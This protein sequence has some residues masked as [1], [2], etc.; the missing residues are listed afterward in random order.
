MRNER[1]GTPMS[2]LKREKSSTRSNMKKLVKKVA[3]FIKRRSLFRVRVV[4]ASAKCGSVHM[5]MHTDSPRAAEFKLI[6]K[7]DVV[8]L[9]IF[10]KVMDEIL[11]CPYCVVQS[12]YTF[13]I[14]CI[15]FSFFFA[16]LSR[17]QD[18]YIF[19]A[20]YKTNLYRRNFA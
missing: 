3:S 9:D 2:P 11:I 17:I 14:L 4:N 6:F 18:R 12:N 1:R 13:E 16:R 5:C 20:L 7:L 10:T 8:N 19:V 15:R